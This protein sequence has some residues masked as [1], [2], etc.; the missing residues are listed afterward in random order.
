MDQEG[1]L[2]EEGYLKRKIQ[3]C[4]FGASSMDQFC[5]YVVFTG[6]LIAELKIDNCSIKR[7][8]ETGI[9][10]KSIDPLIEV[11]FNGMSK[12]TSV[13]NANANPEWNQNLTFDVQIPYGHMSDIQEWVE[14]QHF[15]FSL[16]DF[17]D[18]GFNP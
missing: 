17:E 18:D 3:V 4:I 10:Y 11:T 13:V 12:R 9:A 14:R 8:M 1:I 2:T 7:R 15:E 6:C 16:F 5:R